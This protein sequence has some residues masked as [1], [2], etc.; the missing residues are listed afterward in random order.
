MYGKKFINLF[1]A[2]FLLGVAAA[3]GQAMQ[4]DE[5]GLVKTLLEKAQLE[6]KS[7][8]TP[9]EKIDENVLIEWVAGCDRSALLKEEP[10]RRDKDLARQFWERYKKLLEL[11]CRYCVVGGRCVV[12]LEPYVYAT[13]LESLMEWGREEYMSKIYDEDGQFL[14]PELASVQTSIDLAMTRENTKA[15]NVNDALRKLQEYCEAK[16]ARI[17]ESPAFYECLTR[18]D[19]CLG[20]FIKSLKGATVEQYNALMQLLGQQG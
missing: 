14:D 12:V 10:W 13:S 8:V 20:A 18:L 9:V 4:V 6:S 7:F 3:R 17:T 16:G 15:A 1:F 19:E 2:L 5:P 11:T